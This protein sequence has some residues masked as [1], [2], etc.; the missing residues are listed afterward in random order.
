MTLLDPSQIRRHFAQ[1]AAGFDQAAA[2]P[3]EAGKRLF[4]SLDYLDDRQPE[5][6]VE[7]GCGTGHNAALL[8][9]RWP[10]AQVIAIDAALPMLQQAKAQAG[11]WK[12]FKRLAADACALPLA[13]ASVDLLVSNLCLPFVNDLPATLAGFRR[14]LKPGGLLLC[15]TYGS[16]T[17]GELDHAFSQA[18]NAPHV[19]P[20]APIATFGDALM[21]AGF[22]D[23][24][25]DRDLFTLTYAD[26]P[27]LMA[28]LRAL[29]YRNARQDRRR[30]LTGRG[31]F[32][33]A[34]RA[35]EAMRTA[36][37]RLPSTW[38]VLYA[39]AWAPEAGTPIREQG[40]DIAAVPIS[41]IPIRRRQS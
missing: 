6:I 29:G 25:I 2:L 40:Q 17:L 3:R 1:A 30:T 37:G 35:Y 19:H 22:R 26:L 41:A 23:P 36:D 9:K 11:W 13:D 32:A 8:K 10:K 16:E 27:A 15:S 5:V 4:E 18:D 20:F 31:R 34:T 28:E 21:R 39:H 12:P 38:E 24:V 7:V 14:V 33:A